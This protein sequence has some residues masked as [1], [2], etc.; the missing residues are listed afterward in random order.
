MRTII[1][2][3]FC[4]TIQCSASD[5][6]C[7]NTIYGSTIITEPVLI[8]LINC[9]AMQRLKAIHQYGIM[10]YIENIPPY[11][12]YEHSIGVFFLVRKFG[13]SLLEQIAALLHDVSHTVFSHVGDHIFKHCCQKSSYQDSIH[14]RFIQRTEIPEILNR[15]HIPLEKID[16]KNGTF[17]MLEQDIP[18][19]CADRLE[20]M[21][22]GGL[23]ENKLSIIDIDQII[24][25]LTFHKGKWILH[26]QMAAEKLAYAALYLTEYTFGSAFNWIT[27][28]L[29]AQAIQRALDIGLIT[30]D[31]IH[32][33]IDQR[34]WEILSKS[35]DQKINHCLQQLLQANSSYQIT[36]H[37]DS[38]D[39]H[40][41][42][43]FRG[44]DPWVQTEKGVQRLSNMNHEYANAYAEVKKR[45]EKGWY[46][47]MMPLS[48]N[49]K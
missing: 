18:E 47:K 39:Y 19:L 48:L 2:L 37:I 26:S 31:D 1:S 27:Y 30:L 9:P 32:Y 25:S 29:T 24:H 40:A 22:Y 3:V 49:K 35:T 15:Y 36:N 10:Y 38:Y 42:V 12:R 20:Y 23:L 44:I 28:Q 41:Q 5:Q 4:I 8:E 43:K 21:L 7:I 11:S 34:I 45:L 6:Y 33:S 14:L 46:I 17:F 16:H 13:G